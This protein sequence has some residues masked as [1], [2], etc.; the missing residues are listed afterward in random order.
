MQCPMFAVLP[1]PQCGAA[2]VEEKIKALCAKVLVTE[3]LAELEVVAR[4]LQRALHEHVKEIVEKAHARAMA[5]IQLLKA[6]QFEPQ[7]AE[8]SPSKEAKI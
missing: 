6:S 3:D 1:F 2:W 4:Q 8:S 5:Q 7:G